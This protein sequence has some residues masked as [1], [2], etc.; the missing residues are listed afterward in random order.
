MNTPRS[1]TTLLALPLDSE[2]TE[3]EATLLNRYHAQ[4]IRTQLSNRARAAAQAKADAKAAARK[5]K[6]GK[7][8][9]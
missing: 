6:A 5:A 2:I 3:Q 1:I 4:V 8:Q 7:A 9:G